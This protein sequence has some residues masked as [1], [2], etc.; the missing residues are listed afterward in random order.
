MLVPEIADAIAKARV[1]RIYVCNIMTQPGETENY[2]VADHI[3]AID[4]VCRKKIFDAVLVHRKAPSLELLERYAEENSHPVYIDR[5]A[6]TRLGR[7]V[8][9]ANIMDEKNSI[10]S[11]RHDSNQLAR[12]L[13]RWY[14]G[15][16][17]PKF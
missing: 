3:R 16:W 1:P 15:K 13:L 7:R 4:R 12:V 11:I 6:I 2:T 17:Q 9:I 14:S 10:H 8:V 5:E